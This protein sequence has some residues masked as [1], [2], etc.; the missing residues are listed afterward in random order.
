[1]GWVRGKGGETKNAYRIL[2]EKRPLGDTGGYYRIILRWNVTI[3]KLSNLN[4][5][6]NFVCKSG[7]HHV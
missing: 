4:T 1:M 6:L 5:K 7:M 2:V 3:K